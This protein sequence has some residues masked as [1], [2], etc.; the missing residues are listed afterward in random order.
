MGQQHIPAECDPRHI[1]WVILCRLCGRSCASDDR[2]PKVCLAVA[3]RNTCKS[4]ICALIRQAYLSLPSQS[5]ALFVELV[6]QT[7]AFRRDTGTNPST[8][9]ASR[10]NAKARS[11]LQNYSLWLCGAYY[12]VYQ[13]IEGKWDLCKCRPPLMIFHQLRSPIGSSC[14]L[15][16]PDMQTQPQQLRHLRY[17][18]WEWRS[19]A[20]PWEQ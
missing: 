11:L 8:E 7:W 20:T 3:L 15:C 18:G 12:F 14:S 9:I 1:A 13:G 5:C 4:S 10:G 2:S 19:D 16:A 17:S 6:V